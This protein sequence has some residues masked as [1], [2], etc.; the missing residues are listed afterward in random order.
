MA[1]KNDELGDFERTIL[2]IE[3]EWILRRERF[4]LK[5]LGST[6]GPKIFHWNDGLDPH[7]DI[8]ALGAGPGRMNELLIT[9]GMADRPLPGVPRGG[10]IPRRI[11]LV[12]E[13]PVVEDWAPAVLREIATL[14]FVHGTILAEGGLI[15]GSRPIRKGSWLRHAV[16]GPAGIPALDD[17]L[18]EGEPVS[19]LRAHFITEREFQY[20]KDEGGIRLLERLEKAGVGNILSYG[21]RSVV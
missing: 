18:V 1:L 17:F 19:F 15:C 16:L 14:P 10:P 20:G 13:I 11:E 9:G 5:T 8:Y 4:Y 6:R 7:I 3:A 12:F 2:D 21:R